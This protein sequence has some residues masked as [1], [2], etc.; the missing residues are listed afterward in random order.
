MAA[1]AARAAAAA[2]AVIKSAWLI[3]GVCV[4][5]GVMDNTGLAPGVVTVVVMGTSVCVVDL[6]VK[7]AANGGPGDDVGLLQRPLVSSVAGVELA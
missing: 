2:T 3:A 5:R 7:L 4:S 6:L 1:V